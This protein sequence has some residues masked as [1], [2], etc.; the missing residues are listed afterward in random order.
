VDVTEVDKAAFV[1]AS[2]DEDSEDFTVV[3]CSVEER[4][5]VEEVVLELILASEET[6]GFF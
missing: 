6:S 4:E 3:D 1:E 2:V 5:G